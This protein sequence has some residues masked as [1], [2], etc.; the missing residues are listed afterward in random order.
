M[1]GRGKALNGRDEAAERGWGVSGKIDKD[2]QQ[3][4]Q[5]QAVD[6]PRGVNERHRKGSEKAANGIDEAAEMQ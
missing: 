1:E 4:C 2:R 3:N 6:R 5:R